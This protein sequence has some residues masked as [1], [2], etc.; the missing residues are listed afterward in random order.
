MTDQ[1]KKDKREATRVLG[2]PRNLGGFVI[3][4]FTSIVVYRLFTMELDL[5]FDFTSLLA[6]F[7][8]LFAISLSA[9]FYFRATQTSERFYHDMHQFTA[10]NSE[11]QGR[12]EER[13]GGHFR[14]LDERTLAIQSKFDRLPLDI[15]EIRKKEEEATERVAKVTE[16]TER[17]LNEIID[18]A[19]AAEEER[20]AYKTKLKNAQD[21]LQRSKQELEQLQDR[22]RQA[23]E[24][25]HFQL[26][27]VRHFLRVFSLPSSAYTDSA[28][29]MAFSKY[30]LHDLNEKHVMYMQKENLL[31]EQYSLTEKGLVFAKQLIDN[32]AAN[33]LYPSTTTT[34][35]TTT[36]PP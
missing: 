17:I 36:Q 7:L 26:D 5:Q 20:E 4:A 3:I 13:F 8:A 32:I 21:E 34:T 9:L 28:I 33:A 2:L 27:V 12:I 24:P 11:L 22:I 16:E 18:R 19:T 29:I 14:Q 31:D 23:E 1:I 6:L 10:R 25:E 35:T 30:I 15:T